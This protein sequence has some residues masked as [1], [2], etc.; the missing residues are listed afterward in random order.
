[1][2]GLTIELEQYLDEGSCNRPGK[3]LNALDRHFIDIA[4]N[5]LKMP[6]S[7]IAKTLER[8]R[9]TIQREIR[10]GSTWE[11][12]EKNTYAIGRKSKQDRVLKYHWE[13]AERLFRKRQKNKGYG[14][15][16][17][18]EKY[19]DAAVWYH[20]MIVVEGRS[21][22]EV[23]GRARIE[24]KLSA[25]VCFKTLYNYSHNGVLGY[26]DKNLPMAEIERK[27]QKK[28]YTY[29]QKYVRGESIEFRSD[30]VNKRQEFGHWEGDLIVGKRGGKK[31]VIL[32]LV[33]RK[34]RYL[35]AVVL[36][37]KEHENVAAWFD[38]VELIIG[39]ERFANIFRSVTWDNGSEFARPIDFETSIF[40]LLGISGSYRTRCFYAHAYTS[41]ERGS[42][43][44]CN[45]LIRRNGIKKG[46]DIEEYGQEVVRQVAEKI[47]NKW[48]KIL[49]YHSAK[50]YFA[51]EMKLIE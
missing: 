44:N 39:E 49:G 32:T 22:D 43:E 36:A 34:T 6:V 26:S 33:E 21:P 28:R 9:R 47:N 51:R 18:D 13:A 8:S 30:A 25:Y 15:K 45:G 5:E 20:K 27:A 7:K 1:M 24:G 23:C 11:A 35:I 50:E 16:L 4:L 48:R 29:K 41:W 3:Y 10:R 17:A 14:L 31:E 12:A 40:E 38:Q 19:M 37:S 42:N 2:A 46:H